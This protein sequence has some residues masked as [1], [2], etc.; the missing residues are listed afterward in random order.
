GRA[1]VGPPK[2]VFFAQVHHPGRLAASDFTHMNSLNVTIAEQPFD[3]MLFHFVLTYSNWEAATICFSESYESLSEGLQNALWELGGVPQLHR[4]DR[5]TAAI[6]P[7]GNA[8]FNQR[9]RA[10]LSHYKL[11]AQVINVRAAHEN[12]DCEQS[13]HRFKRAV[14]QALL[15]RGSSDFGSRVEY[16]AWLRELLGQLNSGRQKRL[17]EELPLLRPLP[18]ARLEACKRQKVRVDRGST[19]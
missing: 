5:L 11:T 12:G 9:Y 3:H 1:A 17:N 15:L 14:K 13:H 10:L 16:A 18:A 4:T 7:G 19:V 2:E 8:E 6:P